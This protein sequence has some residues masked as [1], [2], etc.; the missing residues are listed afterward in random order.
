MRREQ[1]EIR[2]PAHLTEPLR[3]GVA[4]RRG[5]ESVAFALASHAVSRDRTLVLVRKVITLPDEAYA[6]APGHGAKWTGAS[7]V[8]LLN[9]ALANDLGVVVF[10]SHPHAG[11]VAMSGDDRDSA[12]KLLP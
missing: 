5:R 12:S 4:P 11:P 2:V 6:R 10:H 3:A 9:E 1:V 7:M 8:P